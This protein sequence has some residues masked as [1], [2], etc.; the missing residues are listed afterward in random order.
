MQHTVKQR[1][2]PVSPRKL[3]RT[4][5]LVVSKPVFE[6]LNILN[7]VNYVGADTLSKKLRE[8][9]G[10]ITHQGLG[11]AEACIVRQV[12]VDKASHLKRYKP[13]AQGRSYQIRREFSHL[14]IMLEEVAS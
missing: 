13:R 9:I 11:A 6:A 5:S 10:N 4:A 1:N 2:I 14:S 3:R 12:L 7:A 8:A